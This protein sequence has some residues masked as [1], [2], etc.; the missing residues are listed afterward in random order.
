VELVLFDGGYAGLQP[1][2]GGRANLCLVVRRGRLRALGHGWDALLAAMRAGSPH[3]DARLAGGEPC[4]ARP[5]GLSSIPYGYLCKS[6]DG[7]YRLGDQA[8]VIPSFSGDGMSIA[9]H[10][11]ELAAQ[12]FLA[13]GDADTYQHRLARDLAAQVRL[14]TLLSRGLVRGP[15]QAA[16]SAAARVWPGLMSS[17]ATRTR[18]SDAALSRARTSPAAT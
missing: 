10:S 2:E 17:I 4:W 3:L 5:L 11:A 8:A 16:L 15:A 9:L 1:V 18:V 6:A 14:A 13:G 7:L 12:V